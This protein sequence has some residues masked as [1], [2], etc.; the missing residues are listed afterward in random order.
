MKS[1]PE[2]QTFVLRYKNIYNGERKR[3]ELAIGKII[4]AKTDEFLKFVHF[5]AKNGFFKSLC[6]TLISRRNSR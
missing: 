5:S 1:L 4:S 3:F 6:Y 2:R